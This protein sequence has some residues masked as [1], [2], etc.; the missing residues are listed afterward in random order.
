MKKTNVREIIPHKNKHTEATILLTSAIACSSSDKTGTA[1]AGLGFA[2]GGTT[3][4][5]A[6]GLGDGFGAGAEKSKCE[7]K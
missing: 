5:A 3:G 1:G 7:F 4:L 6:A 2:L